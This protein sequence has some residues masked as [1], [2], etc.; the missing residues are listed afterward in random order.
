MKSVML[1][2]S[3][4]LAATSSVVGLEHENIP[5]PRRRKNPTADATAKVLT[6]YK[7]RL[8]EQAA[9]DG[10]AL[11]AADA[12]RKR[13]A[14]KLRAQA[15]KGSIAVLDAAKIKR[16][17][18]QVAAYVEAYGSDEPEKKV[19]TPRKKKAAVE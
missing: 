14:A 1:A 4:I 18:A 5:M 2:A 16:S 6:D 3:A 9:L 8:L 12:K 11:Q 7:Q 13:K 10:A 19:K 15:E 17:E